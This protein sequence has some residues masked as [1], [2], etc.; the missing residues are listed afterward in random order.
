MEVT[1]F[2]AG[3]LV[4]FFLSLW[5]LSDI[6]TPHEIAQQHCEQSGFE[7]GK[8]ENGRIQCYRVEAVK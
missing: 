1:T 6:T 8:Y 4:G 5:L 2:L 3:L 7:L